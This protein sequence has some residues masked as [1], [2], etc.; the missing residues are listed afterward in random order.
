V[1]E[2]PFIRAESQESFTSTTGKHAKKTISADQ[3]DADGA[4][5]RGSLGVE[6]IIDSILFNNDPFQDIHSRSPLVIPK[7]PDAGFHPKQIVTLLRP[8]PHEHR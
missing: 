8:L 7:E 4:L 3:R 6:Q 1:P 5:I 2:K